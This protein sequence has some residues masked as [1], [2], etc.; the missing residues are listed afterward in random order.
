M[1]FNTY[2]DFTTHQSSLLMKTCQNDVLIF[3][4]QNKISDNDL[5]FFGL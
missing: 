2:L 3:A 5:P 4:K 1:L